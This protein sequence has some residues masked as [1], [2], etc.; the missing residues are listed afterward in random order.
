MGKMLLCIDRKTPTVGTMVGPTCS[1]PPKEFSLIGEA[2]GGPYNSVHKMLGDVQL[3]KM[4][5][6][7]KLRTYLFAEYVEIE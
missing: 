3:A 7:N 2:L 1:I 5:P 4:P 6:S